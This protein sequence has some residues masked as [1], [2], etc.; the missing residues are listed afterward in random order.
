KRQRTDH[1][2][3]PDRDIDQELT[4]PAVGG[5][6]LRPLPVFDFRAG[7]GG[8]AAGIGLHTHGQATS[9]LCARC[10]RAVWSWRQMCERNSE[11]RGSA[12]TVS[13]SRGCS[14]GTSISSLTRPGRALITA[15]R[16]PSK[17]ASSIEWVMNTIV[18]RS[19]GR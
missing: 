2:D 18:L 4:P 3:Q 5:D 6:L 9:A 19:S 14:K 8:D 12:R 17:I 7:D 15:T 11:K 10:G 16:S 1:R 13:T